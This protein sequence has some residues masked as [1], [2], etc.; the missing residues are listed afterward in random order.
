MTRRA[1]AWRIPAAILLLLA[2]L[3]LAAPH[4]PAEGY[5]RRIQASLENALGRPVTIRQVHFSFFLTPAFTLE[6]VV[7]SDSPSIG[8]EP[9]AYVSE[10]TAR[11]KLWAIL[12]GRMEFSS[13]RLE[14][15][16]INLVKTGAASE[17]GHW[18]FEALLNR[19][20]I[21]AFPEIRMVGETFIG[22]SR[23]NFKFG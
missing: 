17:P 20:F 5:R 11:P 22:A 8:I 14:G 13:V 19:N 18:N 4:F 9:L 3:A 15:A 12:L 1:L 10:L 21:A 23:I 16:S 6:D 2:V 7:I